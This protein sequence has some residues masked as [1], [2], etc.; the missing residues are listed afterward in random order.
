MLGIPKIAEAVRL[1][2]PQFI[3]IKLLI[4][5]N[6]DDLT[7]F[8]NFYLRKCVEQRFINIETRNAVAVNV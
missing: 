4:I 7:V 6:T 8:D 3:F 5:Q 1:V 2:F